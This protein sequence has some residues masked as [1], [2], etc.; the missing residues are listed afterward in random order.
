MA[1]FV[2]FTVVII[3]T[4]RSFAGRN[5]RLDAMQCETF[6]DLVRVKGFVADEGI[7][8]H[9]VHQHFDE[10]HVMTLT[11]NQHEFDEIAQSIDKRA[12]FRRQPAPRTPD[13]LIL[14]PPFAPAPC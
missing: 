7:A 3:A 6:I 11:G 9:A 13:G 1:P 8:N 5:D 10:V 4:F 12:D 14:S 2:F